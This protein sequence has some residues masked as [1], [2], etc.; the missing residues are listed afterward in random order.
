MTENDTH[1]RNARLGALA[2]AGGLLISGAAGLV[3]VAPLAA[4]ALGVSGLGWLTQ[5]VQLRVPALLATAALLLLGYVTVYQR[6]ATC[7]N[8]ARQRRTKVWLW[9]A[10]AVAAAVN[11]LE[12]LILPAMG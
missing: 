4:I 8:P 7:R 2:A 3:C 10:T 12:F 5:Y 11:A 9:V 6:G 1:E